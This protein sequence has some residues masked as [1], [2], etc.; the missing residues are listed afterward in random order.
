M[1]KYVK[2]ILGQIYHLIPCYPPAPPSIIAPTILMGYSE[3]HRQ[4]TSYYNSP[5]L[6]P[7]IQSGVLHLY[8]S[9]S[10]LMPIFWKDKINTVWSYIKLLK[11]LL[12]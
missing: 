11:M 6:G 3:R 9:F 7:V 4:G 1:E 5:L 2:T 8:I 10:M 12:P